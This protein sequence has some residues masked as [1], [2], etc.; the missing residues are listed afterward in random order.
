MDGEQFR[1]LQQEETHT[2]LN[3]LEIARSRLSTLRV[4]K[5]TGPVEPLFGFDWEWWIGNNEQGWTRYSVQA[6]RLDLK[7]EKYRSLRHKVGETFQ[8][9]LL[10]KFS[11]ENQSV[12]LYCFY[13]ALSPTSPE[14]HWY[15]PLP[16]DKR[17]LGCT[18]V[19]LRIV[20]TAHEKSKRKSFGALH[21]TAES[22]PWRCL[23][24]CPRILGMADSP[25]HPSEYQPGIHSRLP[26]FLQQ[27]SQSEDGATTLDLDLEMYRGHG[28]ALP[29]RLAV[30][31]LPPLT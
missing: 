8:I 18:L 4:Y 30:V 1:C 31:S 29:K 23:F 17:Q 26:D 21:S 14:A 27:A 10:E 19:P 22:I 3:L 12:P 5:A 9:D 7:T 24:C 6:K 13:N 20:K 16:L 28:A 11:R 25:L 2:D 15:C